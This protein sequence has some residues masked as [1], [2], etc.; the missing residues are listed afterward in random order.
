[1]RNLERPTTDKAPS[2]LRLPTAFCV[3]RLV[4]SDR[5]FFVTAAGAT[6]QSGRR[7]PIDTRR[8]LSQNRCNFLSSCILWGKAILPTGERGTGGAGPGEIIS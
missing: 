7:P 4:S 3:C 2:W 8:V 6:D 1:M 5:I